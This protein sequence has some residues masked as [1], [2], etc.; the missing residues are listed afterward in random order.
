MLFINFHFWLNNLE[1]DASRKWK[2]FISLFCCPLDTAAWGGRTT[3]PPTHKRPPYR[4]TYWH[5]DTFQL[6]YSVDWNTVSSIC[7]NSTQT[8]SAYYF[9][10]TDNCNIFRVLLHSEHFTVLISNYLQWPRGVKCGSPAARLLILWVPIL[11]WV[12]MSVCDECCVLS[13]R[14]LRVGLITRP[15][16]SYRV[17]CALVSSCIVHNK[18]H[19]TQWE[20]LT[21]VEK[22]TQIYFNSILYQ[23]SFRS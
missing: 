10:K 20:L 12:R 14:G 9:N 13:G 7:L 1:F 2:I 4:H 8:D 6:A 23:Y 21:I 11:S 5:V 18:E 15:E 22:N 16:K 3:L 19:L 17:W